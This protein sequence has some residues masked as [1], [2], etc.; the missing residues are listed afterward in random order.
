LF[1]RPQ[2]APAE[3]S[4]LLT[5]RP[6]KGS[7]NDTGRIVCA[8]HSVGEKTILKAIAEQGANNIEMIGQ[9]TKAGTG[10][11]S[12]VPEIRRLIAKH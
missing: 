3:L 2:L 7:T 4:G 8:C 12:C 9:Y 10:C 5:A 11:G 1:A 6:P